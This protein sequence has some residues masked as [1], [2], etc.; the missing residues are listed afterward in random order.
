MCDMTGCKFWSWS[1][2][3]SF[4]SFFFH[5]ILSKWL[6]VWW[7][8]IY[9]FV[10]ESPIDVKAKK[11]TDLVIFDYLFFEFSV[12]LHHLFGEYF[13]FWTIFH[14]LFSLFFHFLFFLFFICVHMMWKTPRAPR[15]LVILWFRFVCIISTV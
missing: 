8:N 9:V 10:I 6:F 12:C 2:S 15:Y 7:W 1:H 5:A 4:F 11:K 3:F 14:F 13:M